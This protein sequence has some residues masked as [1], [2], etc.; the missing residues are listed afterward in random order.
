MGR[1]TWSNNT[2]SCK[3]SNG[4][5]ITN[6]KMKKLYKITRLLLSLLYVAAGF[7]VYAGIYNAFDIHSVVGGIITF[8]IMLTFGCFIEKEIN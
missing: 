1:N 8:V 3:C 7:G 5:T 2:Y 6:N 4:I